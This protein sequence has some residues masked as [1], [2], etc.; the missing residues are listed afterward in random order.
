MAK[1]TTDKQAKLVRLISENVGL[2]KPKTMLELRATANDLRERAGLPT[3]QF[4]DPL[5]VNVTVIGA[6]HIL[7]LRA[8]LDDLVVS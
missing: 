8:A 7:E 3:L 1:R 6:I 5:I 4:T 2:A